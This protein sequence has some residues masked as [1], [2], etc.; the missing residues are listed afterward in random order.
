MPC[1][2]PP[3]CSAPVYTA[4]MRRL[5]LYVAL[6]A[7]CALPALASAQFDSGT[8][9]FTVSVDPT[10]PAPYSQVTLTP[11][12]G[13]IDIT[14]ATMIVTVGGKE[15]YRGNAQSVPITLGGPGA[16]LAIVVR[17]QTATGSYKQN[18]PLAPQDVVL[19]AEP[20]ASAPPL[21]AGKPLVPLGGSVRVVAMADLRTSGG[22]RLDPAT[23][24]YA[25][26]VDGAQIDSA[27]G[28]GKRAVIV[29]SPLQYRSRTI[30]VTV[31]SPDGRLAGSDSF[32]LVGSDPTLRI[33]ERDPLLG[34]RFDHALGA[35]Y[36]LTGS[37][38]TL[39]GAAYSFPTALGAPVLR[40][41]LNGA[42]VQSGALLTLRP[43]GTKAGT[44]S[45]SLTGASG[46]VS[47]ASAGLT[48]SYGSSAST[49][50]FGL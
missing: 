9:P 37:E 49:N 29:D 32:D 5:T 1:L 6:F 38:A 19:V 18:L 45:L 13:Q 3:N 36:T 42:A 24:A 33:Y 17:M 21:Y 2:A 26:S 12:S 25:W 7:L 22:A 11:V 16:T 20:L 8:N 35:S 14:N 41:F 28:I 27:S 44:A 47:T 46:D 23:L 4:C 10:S 30:A 31:T 39:Y 50:I 15:V 40:W 34:I 43:T 48:V